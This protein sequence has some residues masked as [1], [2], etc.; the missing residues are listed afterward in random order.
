MLCSRCNKKEAEITYKEYVEGKTTTLFLC[1]ECAEELANGIR[2][3]PEEEMIPHETL[4][5]CNVCGTSLRDFR[6]N[7]LMGCP[8]CYDYFLPYF[9]EV[10]DRIIHRSYFNGE[11]LKAE[12]FTQFVE[13]EL[14]KLKQT[15]EELKEREEFK[16]AIKVRDRIRKLENILKWIS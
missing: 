8:T 5:K 13:S 14:Q 16:E 10:F 3:I 7:F 4:I 1:R 2:I 15:L 6:N 12:N 9:K 11:R